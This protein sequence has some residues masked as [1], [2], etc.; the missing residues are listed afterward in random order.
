MPDKSFFQ[1]C[2]RTLTLE[3]LLPTLPSPNISE[4]VQSPSVDGEVSSICVS[5]LDALGK[6]EKEAR[7][8]VP[9]LRD[10]W[11]CFLRE[12]SIALQLWHL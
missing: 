9:A 12:S 2:G 7:L 5:D 8:K 1:L 4:G 10:C 3:I 11:Q 6:Q